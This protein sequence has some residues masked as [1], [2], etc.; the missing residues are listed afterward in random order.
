MAHGELKK[1]LDGETDLDTY[2]RRI[3][4]L[5]ADLRAWSQVIELPPLGKGPLQGAPFGVKDIFDAEGTRTA[6]GSPLFADRVS[7]RDSALVRQLRE[8]GGRVLG[9]THTTSFAY[10]DPAPTVNPHNRAHTPGGSSSGSA[11]AV[12][13]GMVPFALGSQTQGSVCRPA[14]YCGVAGFKPTHGLLSLEGVMP[15]APTLDTAGLFTQTAGDMLLLWERM[16]YACNAFPGPDTPRLAA[17]RILEP[18][19]EPPMRSAFEA[20]VERLG[21]AWIEPPDVYLRLF[22]AVRR[23]QDTEGARSLEETYRAHGRGVGVKLAEMIERGLATTADEY[24]AALDTLAAG[25]DDM[26]AVFRQYD[27][28]LTP[29]AVGPAPPTLASTGDPRM[30]SPWTGLGTPSLSIPIAPSA[31]S[32]GALPLGLQLAAARNRDGELLRAAI[33]LEDRMAS[34]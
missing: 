23:I 25:R 10:F 28:I 11:A 21:I 30:N 3:A 17:F 16:G 33:Q 27:V 14:S 12:A 29:A 32:P 15:F 2:R 22:P 4:E 20:L 7:P 26:D 13:C 5:D 18:E 31:E 9:K 6:F 24:Q 34:S 19:V 1:F 8:R